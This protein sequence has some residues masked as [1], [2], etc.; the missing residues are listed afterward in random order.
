VQVRLTRDRLPALPS[1]A[2]CGKQ[3]ADQDRDDADDDEE[4]DE[5]EGRGRRLESIRNSSRARS[6][7]N[8]LI[9]IT[10]LSRFGCLAT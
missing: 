10:P 3:H 4:F 1:F 2:Q 6:T 5:R 8:Q 9:P 7:Q